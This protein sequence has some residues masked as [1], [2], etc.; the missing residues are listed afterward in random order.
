MLRSIIFK[1]TDPIHQRMRAQRSQLAM[2]IMRPEPTMSLLDLGGSAGFS[3]E[4]DDLRSLFRR[5]VVVNL[6]A[7]N[8]KAL[9]PNV[10]FECADACALPYPD[11]S[12][13]WVFSNAVIEHVGDRR[14]QEM[15][16]RETQRIARVGYFVATPNRHFFLDPHTYFPFYHLLPENMQRIAIHFSFGHMRQWEPLRVLSAKELREMFPGAEVKASGLLST[17]LV[18]YRRK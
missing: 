16:A 6:D 15:F 7:Q 13:D 1:A 18:A 8:E 14:R 12:F 10:E 3:G 9:L 2:Q 4:Y 17:N 5:V 11:E